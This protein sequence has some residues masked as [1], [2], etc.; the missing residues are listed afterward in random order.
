MAEYND[1][2]GCRYC[3][4]KHPVECCPRIKRVEYDMGAIKSVEFWP[5]LYQEGIEVLLKDLISKYEKLMEMIQDAENKQ[6]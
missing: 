6:E 3:G 4:E 5:P 1:G 2:P